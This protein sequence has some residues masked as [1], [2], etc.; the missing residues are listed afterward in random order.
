MSDQPAYSLSEIAERWR[1]CHSHV[2]SL[3]RRGDLVAINIGTGSRSRYVVTSEALDDFEQ[4][5]T[6]TPPAAL[7]KKRRANIR[8]GDVIEFF[9]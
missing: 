3:V 1:C 4:R 7:E 2:L 8:R 6:V 9:T 5:R